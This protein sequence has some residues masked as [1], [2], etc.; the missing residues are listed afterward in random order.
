LKP[1]P[2]WGFLLASR[3]NWA[4]ETSASRCVFSEPQIDHFEMAITSFEARIR[5]SPP[6][7]T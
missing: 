4:S 5:H 2:A 3:V 7:T 1:L 6:Q